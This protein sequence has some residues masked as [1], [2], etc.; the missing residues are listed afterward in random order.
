MDSYDFLL[1]QEHWL[2]N[3]Q[4]HVFNDNITNIHSFGISGMDESKLHSGR[5][6]GGCAILWRDVLSCKVTPIIS[7]N[8]RLCVVKIE[9]SSYAI[10]LCSIYMPCDSEYDQC[11]NAIYNGV[12]YDILKHVNDESIDFVIIGGDFNTDICRSKSLHTMSLQ[13]FMDNENF[14]LCD[15]H[16]CNNVDYT[17]ESTSNRSRSTLDH[18]M[19]SENMFDFISN[20]SVA[21]DADNV[22]DHSV[23]PTSLNIS[24][25]YAHTAVH[26]EAKRVWAPA[27]DNDINKYKQNIDTLLDDSVIDPNVLYCKNYMCTLHRDAIF[28]LHDRIINCC[29]NASQ[30]ISTRNSSSS[31]KQQKRIPGWNEY[32]QPYRSDA[33]FWHGLWKENGSPR[34]GPWQI[35]GAAHGINIITHYVRFGNMRNIYKLLKW[36]KI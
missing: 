33:L 16:Q 23:L 3:S 19:V 25:E 1:I 8:T 21:H 24:V 6:Y 7:D 9:F 17:Y 22:S 29:L 5:P 31:R 28:S 27:T 18:F 14:I 36:Q 11:N 20:L 15:N 32:V 10:I 34:L 12:L 2:Y 13:T 26:N 4:L 30:C 35:L